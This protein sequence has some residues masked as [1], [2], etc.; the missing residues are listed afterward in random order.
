MLIKRN[1]TSKLLVVI[2]K[3]KRKFIIHTEYFDANN[4]FSHLFIQNLKHKPNMFQELSIQIEISLKKIYWRTVS[5]IKYTKYY[6]ST[7]RIV[8]REYRGRKFSKNDVVIE[9][10][11]ISNDFE[12]REPEIYKLVTTVTRDDDSRNIYTVPVGR[13]NELTSFDE[14][15]YEEKRHNSL[16]CPGESISKKELRKISEKNTVRLYIVPGVP[17]LLYQ[18]V[19]HNSCIFIMLGISIELY[20]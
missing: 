15:K 12:L 2:T 7:S 11:W 5:I 17:A 19:N 13:C 4:I 10:S 14:S 18:K 6:A 9:P 3:K 1:T 20:G 16:I 8:K